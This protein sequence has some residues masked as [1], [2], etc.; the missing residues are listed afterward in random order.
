VTGVAPSA[1]GRPVATTHEE[2]ELAAFGLFEE[3]GFAQ[4]TMD[5]IAAQVGVSKRTIFRYYPSKN[6]IAWGQFSATLDGFRDVLDEMPSGIPVHAAVHRGILDFNHFPADAH[7]SHRS[8][9]RL[10][11]STP[12]LQA[13]SVLQYAAWRQVIAEYVARRTAARP[14]DHVPRLAGHLS[15]SLALTAYEMWLT[16]P[17][18]DGA[19]LLEILDCSMVSLRSYLD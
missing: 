8:R 19:D 3:H 9:M 2:I 15:L 13:H 16:T 1:L 17:E 6:D 11:L 12:E 18:A 14:D 7:P 5:A 4:T 10:I